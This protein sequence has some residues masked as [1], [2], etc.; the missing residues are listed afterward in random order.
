LLLAA[1]VCQQRKIEKT[2]KSQK[3]IQRNIKMRAE[4]AVNTTPDAKGKCKMSEDESCLELSDKNNVD[5]ATAKLI[6]NKKGM[7]K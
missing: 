2:M 3:K 4:H 6:I 7:Y 5:F 1:K